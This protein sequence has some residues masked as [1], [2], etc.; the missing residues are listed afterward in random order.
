MTGNIL[1]VEDEVDIQEIVSYNLEKAGFTVVA[2]ETGEAA[3][4]L[5]RNEIPDLVV[6]DLMLP[7]IDG[8]EVCRLLKQDAATRKLPILMLTARAE[9]VDRVVGLELGADDYVVKPFS[10]PRARTS[11]P[12]HPEA[13]GG[14]AGPGIANIRCGNDAI[15]AAH[16]RSGGPPG[17]RGRRCTG[18]DFH[19]IQSAGY[20]GGT[21]GARAV[22]GG[23]SEHGVGLRLRR[24][25]PDRGYPCPTVERET[26]RRKR[27]GRNRP[28]RRLP[29]QWR[30]RAR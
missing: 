24:L 29:F 14:T 9:E 30:T 26:G 21:T 25:R 18:I 12:G 1:V 27:N 7:G 13:T 22:P 16:H 4:E 10:A 28:R 19:R 17:N 8:L 5:I 2:V 20:A 3:V 6:L 11:G 15:R 23:T